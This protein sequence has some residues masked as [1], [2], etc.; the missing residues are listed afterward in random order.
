MV[1]K[2]YKLSEEH[3]KKISEALKGNKNGLGNKNCL[4]RKLSE[5]HKQ[6][7]SEAGKGRK[8]SMETRRKMSEA[9]KGNKGSLGQKTPMKTRLKMR[10][11]VS[12]NK[13]P[14]WKGGISSIEK[15]IRGGLEYRLW[16]RAV[17]ARDNHTCQDC[18]SKDH[19][20]SHHIKDFDEYPELRFVVKNGKTLCRKC[21]T[22]L[23]AITRAART[24][25][26][27]FK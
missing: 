6:K 18:G 14:F 15:R 4:G 11:A 19:P 9:S 7:L 3:K 24:L 20:Q 26:Y 17:L 16:K 5:E 13:N 21:H 27:Y 1:R 2:G 25:K 22:K 12:G 23:H 10:E 8:V